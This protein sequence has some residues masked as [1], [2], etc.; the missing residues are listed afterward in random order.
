MN[1][2]IATKFKH[3]WELLF[4]RKSLKRHI[5]SNLLQHDSAQNVRLQR[6]DA[7]A[8]RKQHVQ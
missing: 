3:D 7:D 6:V 4:L 1:N 5:K 2:W 8:S